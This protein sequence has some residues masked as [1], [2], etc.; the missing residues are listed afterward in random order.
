MVICMTFFEHHHL[1][2]VCVAHEITVKQIN[3]YSS[4]ALG[5]SSA[6][7][8]KG[9]TSGFASYPVLFILV[10]RLKDAKQLV[11]VSITGHCIHISG[12]IFT[13]SISIA[14]RIAVLK[15]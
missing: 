11:D 1:R 8:G 4:E 5:Y 12:S 10:Q 6:H 2:Q 15:S 3:H 9:S 7:L 13:V 14:I